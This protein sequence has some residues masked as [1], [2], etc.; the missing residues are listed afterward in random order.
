MEEKIISVGELTQCW[1]NLSNVVKN[2]CKFKLEQF[3][4]AFTATYEL[5]V[6]NAEESK[7]DRG[8]AELVSEAYLFAKMNGDSVD[9]GCLAALILTERMLDSCAFSIR[10]AECGS[11]SIYIIEERKEVYLDFKNPGETV[12]MLKDIIDK[13]CSPKF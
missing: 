1:R 8:I 11:A 5:L 10:S 12:G 3:E 6:K 13:K 7:L 9:N 4:E 2:G